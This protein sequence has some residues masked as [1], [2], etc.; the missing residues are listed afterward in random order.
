MARGYGPLGGRAAGA[1][2]RE[3]ACGLLRVAEGAE[4][5]VD[6]PRRDRDEE[7]LEIHSEQGDPSSVGA[8]VRQNAPTRPEAVRR[9]VRRHPVEDLVEN[10]SLDRLQSRLGRLEEAH[11]AGALGH[12]S[13]DVVTQPG[14]ARVAGEATPVCEPREVRDVLVEPGS[15]I[16]RRHRS[17]CE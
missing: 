7:V 13:V 8:C 5:A 4:H 11:A 17:G 10:P 16:A 6:P 9:L 15:D 14:I 2:T 12:P 3:H 1:K